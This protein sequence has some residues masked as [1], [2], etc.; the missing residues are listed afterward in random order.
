[1]DK[2]QIVLL[3]AVLVLNLVIL[4]KVGNVIR[5]LRTPE[6]KKLN[7]DFNKQGRRVNLQDS[8]PG[9]NP[10]R[11]NRNP[12]QN[13][14]RGSFQQ[15]SRPGQ[16][17]GQADAGRDQQRRDGRPDRGDRNDRDRNRGDRDRNRGDRDRN[18]GDRDRSR[19]SEIYGNESA[20]HQSA[21]ATEPENSS[22][23]QAPSS[24]PQIGGRR[25]LE[26]R[27]TEPAYAPAESSAPASAESGASEGGAEFDPSRIRHGRRPIVKKTP[28]MESEAPA[29]NA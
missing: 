7:P 1:M 15:G 29:T 13:P 5:M 23:V 4:V 2:V 8:R 10:S 9:Q 16:P 21:A 11:D 17:A 14:Q 26:T 27:N 19:R 24:E 25:P 20:E 18:R 22:Q 3:V 28:G 6:V 12:Q